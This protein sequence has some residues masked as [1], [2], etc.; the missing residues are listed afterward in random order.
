MLNLAF[1]IGAS[2]AALGAAVWAYPVI[3]EDALAWAGGPNQRRRVTR[4]KML[5]GHWI[6]LAVVVLILVGIWS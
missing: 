1:N 5:P 4:A 2:L 3:K 6:G